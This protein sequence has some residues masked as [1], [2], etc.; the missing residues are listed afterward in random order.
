[1]MASQ[2]ETEQSDLGQTTRSD[3]APQVRRWWFYTQQIRRGRRGPFGPVEA[4]DEDA[5][6]R[7]AQAR[8]RRYGLTVA[9]VEPK[10]R[11]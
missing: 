6:Y 8:M 2:T 10:D 3:Q 11:A 1:M 5:A 4:P 9:R 7:I